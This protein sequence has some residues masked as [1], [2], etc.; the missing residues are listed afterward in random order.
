MWQSGEPGVIFIDTINKDN[1]YD[2]PIKA[3]NP[4]KLISLCMA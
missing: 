3:T 1:K 2:E 4:C